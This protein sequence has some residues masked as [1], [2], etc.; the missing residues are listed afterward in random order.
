MILM[1]TSDLKV[2]PDHCRLS[3]QSDIYHRFFLI[4][5]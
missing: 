5:T 1:R 4:Q 3:K 2:L